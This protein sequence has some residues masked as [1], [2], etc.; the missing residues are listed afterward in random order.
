MSEAGREGQGSSAGYD[1]ASYFIA[2]GEGWDWGIWGTAVG[3][4][5]RKLSL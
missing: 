2:E 3:V 5:P 4:R 1:S